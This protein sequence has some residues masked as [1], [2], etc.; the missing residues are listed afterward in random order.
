[1]AESFCTAGDVELCY[2]TFGDRADP[3]HA[4][5]HGPG[6]A[7]ARLA[8]RT[9]A[10]SSPGAA[11][12]SSATTTATSAARRAARGAGRRRRGSCCGARASAASYSLADMAADGIGL[13]DHLGIERAHVVGA[14]MGGMIAQLIAA[15][16]PERVLSLASIM[17]NTGAAATRPAGARASTAAA[18]AAAA[19]ARGVHRARRSSCS[20]TIGSPGFARDED[21]LR[22]MA[23]P[24]LRPR[25]RPGRAPPASS[26]RSSPPATARVSCARSP[27]RRSS[28]TARPTGSSRRPAGA[29]RRARSRRAA[30]DDRGHGP[31]PAARR[32]AADRRRDR[33]EHPPGHGG[34]RDGCRRLGPG[35]VAARRPVVR[36]LLAEAV[37][38]RLELVGPRHLGRREV[39]AQHADRRRAAQND[40]GP[41][42]GERRRRAR[43]RRRSPRRRAPPRRAARGARGRS[44]GR[45][46]APP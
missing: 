43:A 10:P 12:S 6:H 37:Q 11:S 33:R 46:P 27:R 26:P 39:A 38:A 22:T 2:E 29:R 17:S 18:A 25:R 3:A 9:S 16:H 42:A 45:W 14:S 8:R 19:R 35:H 21:E 13:L 7:D 5:R 41:R 28:S 34:A 4:A 1:M 24:Q 40:V 44:G 36:A 15:R 30:G 31:R 32:V 23:A 20:R